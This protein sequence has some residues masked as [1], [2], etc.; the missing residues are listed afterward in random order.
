MNMHGEEQ[1]G[2]RVECVAVRGNGRPCGAQRV[3]TLAA[4]C[5]VCGSGMYRFVTPNETDYDQTCRQLLEASE[6][7]EIA[8]L[9]GEL[10]TRDH[11]IVGRLRQAVRGHALARAGRVPS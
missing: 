2:V 3:L 9:R 6:A 10:L 11:P 8:I 4:V 5:F 1:H 7:V